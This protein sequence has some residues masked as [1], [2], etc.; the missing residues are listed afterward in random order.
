MEAPPFLLRLLHT[1][2]GL[3]S[4][5]ISKAGNLN[6]DT[7]SGLRGGPRL[8]CGQRPR[9]TRRRRPAR[10]ML[11]R[12]KSCPRSSPLRTHLHASARTCTH[13]HACLLGFWDD[14]RLYPN[15]NLHCISDAELYRNSVQAE[16]GH[17]RAFLAGE[18]A[19]RRKDEEAGET[20]SALSTSS[21]SFSKMAAGH[22][23]PGHIGC[24]L[25]L[26]IRIAEWYALAPAIKA[27]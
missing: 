1:G 26:W 16:N 18:A 21:G 3:V 11:S 9:A 23:R 7:K 22:Q 14:T 17:Q 13:L 10:R 27:V 6:P 8:R 20:A 19:R 4:K 12:L 25:W 5:Q 2:I 15:L 24:T